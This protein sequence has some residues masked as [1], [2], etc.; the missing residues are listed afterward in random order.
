ML[1]LSILILVRCIVRTR[2]QI[3]IQK[4]N[5][6]ETRIE[7]GDSIVLGPRDVVGIDTV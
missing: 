2:T 6:D 7:G 1:L 4:L 3:Q 5:C